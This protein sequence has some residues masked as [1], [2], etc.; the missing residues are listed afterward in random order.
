MSLLTPLSLCESLTYKSCNTKPAVNRSSDGIWNRNFL[1]ITAI[2]VHVIGAILCGLVWSIYLKPNSQ[3]L[4]LCVRLQIPHFPRFSY[5]FF[6][7]SKRFSSSGWGACKRC[8]LICYS[9]KRAEA[10]GR[11]GSFP[12]SKAMSSHHPTDPVELRR[13]NF[14][15]PGELDAL[16]RVPTPY[17]V[18]CVISKVF[19]S[20][21]IFSD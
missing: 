8:V 1:K 15:T 5:F 21:K 13:I 19:C 2:P 7:C 20:F 14:Q 4:R 18:W 9:R 17:V 3:K 10:E 11:K 12:C 6:L 16:L